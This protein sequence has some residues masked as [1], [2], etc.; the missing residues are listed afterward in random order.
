LTA[1]LVATPSVLLADDSPA[2][3]DREALFKK[4][5]ANGDGQLTSDEVP[6]EQQRLFKRML[7]TSDKDSDGKLSHDEFLAGTKE[8][9]RPAMPGGGQGG[10]GPSPEQLETLFKSRDANGDGKLGVDEV[11]EERREGFLMMIERFDE[12]GD[13]ALTLAEF[14]KGMAGMRGP[15]G[16]PDGQR[17]EGRRPEEGSPGMRPEGGRPGSGPESLFRALDANGDGKISREESYAAAD[18]LKKLDRDGDGALSRAE[19][20]LGGPPPHGGGRPGAPPPG[21]GARA[22]IERNDKNNDGKLSKEEAPEYLARGFDRADTNSDGFLDQAELEH[23]FQAQAAMRGGQGQGS[24]AGAQ[25]FFKQIDKDGDGKISKDE[26][27]ER[28]KENFDRLDANGDGFIVIEEFQ[29][30]MGAMRGQG[31][32]GARRPGGDA[33]APGGGAAVESRFKELDKDGDGK[34]SKDEA[35]ERMRDNFDRIDG[36]SDGFIDLAEMQQA[37][38]A[39]RGRGG[40]GAQRKPKNDSN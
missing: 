23:A 16:R 34:I 25:Q 33:G 22:V 29:R 20:G 21:A 17:P 28:M 37:M 24:G 7:R 10:A 3:E 31:G 27:P 11:P 32:E 6:E 18:A 1:A 14:S 26:A 13:K 2:G 9:S 38:A 12:D 39:G 15:G 5:D 40:D 8:Q 19:A 35:P 36:N 4:L 30:V